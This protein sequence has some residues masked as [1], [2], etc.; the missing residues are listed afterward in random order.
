MFPSDQIPQ[1][2]RGGVL[3]LRAVHK[4]YGSEHALRGV[5]LDLSPGITV[6]LGRNGAGKSTLCHILT[7]ME[8][9][10]S[11]DVVRH[12]S[13]LL[14]RSDWRQHHRATGWLPQQ[15]PVP[16]AMTVEEY[17]RHAA[18]LKALPRKDAS[19]RIDA[20]LVRVDLA[21]LRGRRLG[22]LSGGMLRRAG[23]AQA[24]VHDPD[25]VVLDEPTVGLDPEQRAWFHSALRDLSRDKCVLVSTHLLEDVEAFPGRVVVLDQGRVVF[26]DTT[27]ALI[28]RGEVGGTSQERLRSGFLHVLAESEI[29]P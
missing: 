6:L 18:W 20:A 25:V 1:A 5:D 8:P 29:A 12:G 24:L 21:D 13:P 9:A 11:G 14:T 4:T 3:G 23:I 10:D 15:L 19:D 16:A 2:E 17:L 28:D 26:S 27:E 7:G 22:H